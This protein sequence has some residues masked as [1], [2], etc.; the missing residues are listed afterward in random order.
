MLRF[1]VR[2]WAGTLVTL[3]CLPALLLLYLMWRVGPMGALSLLPQLA[4][5][6]AVIA[7]VLIVR[8]V[9]KG[10]GKA[11]LSKGAAAAS[12]QAARGAVREGLSEG[13]TLLKE[14]AGEAKGTLAALGQRAVDELD[15]F[16]DGQQRPPLMVPGAPRC[17]VCSRFARAGAKFCDGCGAPLPVICQRCGR[18][19][20]P[21]ARFCDTCGAS[22]A[23]D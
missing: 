18:L 10:L 11:V 9:T 1:F 7:A 12:A 20:R 15:R 6:L 17:P 2:H 4:V 16:I 19:L 23:A 13:R 3:F 5:C 14:K 22:T 8:Q 21:E